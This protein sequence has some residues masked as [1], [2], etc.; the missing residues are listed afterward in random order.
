MDKPIKGFTRMRGQR[1]NKEALIAEAA[2]LLKGDDERRFLRQLLAHVSSRDL[3]AR[4]PEALAAAARDLWVRGAQRRPGKPKIAAG[5]PPGAAHSVLEIVNDDMPFLVDS[6][7]AAINRQG[8][9]VHLVVHPVLSVRRDRIGRLV[10]LLE[11]GAAAGDA[12]NESWMLIEFDQCLDR[13]RL[14]DLETCIDSVL[15]DVRAAVADWKPMLAKAE[16]ILRELDERTTGISGHEIDEAK[17]L[18]RWLIED[19]FTFLGYREYA[20]AGTGASTRFS[21]VPQ[22]G[23]GLLR[24]PAF[25]VFE[26]VPEVAALPPEV[27]A[28][29]SAPHLLVVNKAD[30][31]STVHRPAYLDAI[32]IKVFDGQG[33]VIGERLFVG[34]FTSMV[35]IRSPRNIPLLKAKIERVLSRSELRPGG[36]DAKA[37]EHI[38]LSYP[39]DELFQIAEDDLFRIATGI[40]ELQDR[41]RIA[42]FLRHD[43][44][45]RFV[46]ARVYVPRDR[47]STELRQTFQTILERE[48]NGRVIAYYTTLSDDSVSARVHFIIK[49]DPG[50]VSPTEEA[51]I[52]AKLIEAGRSWDEKLRG[53][54]TAARG[55][56]AGLALLAKYAKAFPPG[57]TA[58]ATAEYA[59]ADIER[60]EAALASG[61]LEMNLRRAPGGEPDALRFRLYN[62][63]RRMSLSTVLPLLEAMGFRVEEEEQHTIRPAGSEPVWLHD[64]GL[65]ARRAPAEPVEALADRF[66]AA[67]AAVWDGL[68]ESDGFNALVLAAGL[69]WREISVLRAYAKYLRQAGAPVTQSLIEDAL[70][71]NGA[72]ARLLAELFLVRAGAEKGDEA[73]IATRVEAALESVA[74]LDEDRIM[75]RLLNA[76]RATLR[77]NYRQRA[78]G[79]APKPALALKFDSRALDDLPAPRPLYEIW[80]YSPRL[81]GIHLRFGK[82]ARGGI[83]WSDRRDDF[84]TEILGLVKTQTVKNAVIVPVGAKGGFVLKQPPGGGREALMAEGVACYQIFIRSLLDITDNIKD[85]KVI[86]PKDVTRYDGDDPYLVVAADK[87]TATFSDIANAISGEYGHWLGDAFASGGS[88]GY[89]HKKMGITAR[90]AWVSVLRHFRELGIEPAF[91]VIGVG[92]MSGDVFGNGMLQSRHIKLVAAFD[93]RHI[94]IDPDPE[95]AKSFAERRRLFDL[96]R[97]TWA[98][99]D[100]TV[101]SKGGGVFERAAKSI[102]LAPEAKARFGIAAAALAPAELVKALLRSPADLLYFGGIG[103]YVKSSDER[104]AEAG[105]RAND[106]LRVDGCDIAARVIAEGA[107]LALTQ[108]GRVEY[109]LRGA[110]GKGG[111]LNTD[112]IDNSAG[113]DC[114]D[115][116]VNIKILLA[117]P[118]ARGRLTLGERDRMLA[119]MSEDVAA[120]VLRDN[121]LQTGCLSVSQSVAPGMLD[122]HRRFMRAL[123]RAGRLDRGIEALPDED[124]LAERQAAGHGLT[125]PELAVLL[126]YAKIELQERL[127]GSDLPDDPQLDGEFLRYFPK[128]IAAQFRDAA[129]SHRLKREIVSTLTTN[130]IVNRAGITF[131]HDIEA[132]T[133]R[134]AVEIARAYIMARDAFELRALW[135]EIEALDGKIPAAAQISALLEIGRFIVRATRWFLRHAEPPLDLARTPARY[136]PAIQR[137]AQEVPQLLTAERA[138]A[139]TRGIADCRARGFPEAVAARLALLPEHVALAEIARLAGTVGRPAAAIAR[140]YFAAGARFDLDWLRDAA[141]TARAKAKAYWD[142]MALAAVIDDF[143][144]HQYALAAAVISAEGGGKGLEKWV[145]ARGPAG[146]ETDKLIDELKTGSA[147]PDLAMLAVANRRLRALVGG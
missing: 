48:L 63:G 57:Y 142:R 23:L 19:N 146:A 52:E 81:E 33:G 122:R 107:N 84:R 145:A 47:H 10:G 9:S 70:A 51:A 53:A 79:G 115:H 138:A 5:N 118:M 2:S 143:Y 119:Q 144:S 109:A 125:R 77:T 147:P 22:S 31:R 133:G 114:S 14:N 49:T 78:A 29:L 54:L 96:P 50:A 134:P 75:R 120:L 30:Q 132:E 82:V 110:G 36:H 85:G 37:L 99:Y 92:D 97:S 38:L 24:D 76:M 131:V 123:E 95:P 124:G 103:T 74:S 64:F 65:V 83:R 8:F 87:G 89:D 94:F 20:I 11:P 73:E 129:R 66:H 90:G 39:R 28:F 6:V 32:G 55:E 105:D 141:E 139:L 69:G 112:A 34:L 71:K 130:S 42:L 127:L 117:I 12:C 111:Q 17:D 40:L 88:A 58:A 60:V 4:L 135:A 15:A 13:T 128:P 21:V 113:V 45:E 18:L 68:A 44:Y 41:Q 1:H 26:G 62:R 80:V 35:Y 67:F 7:T 91:T 100:K 86:P 98:D 56:A 136:G 137:L 126:A 106:A 43:P 46:S 25:H 108:R 72:I 116:E 102:K 121:Y 3:E 59:L 93:H 16:A 27:Q 104:H 140:L 61:R 101:I